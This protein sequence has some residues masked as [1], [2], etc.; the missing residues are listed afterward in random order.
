MHDELLGRAVKCS[1]NQIAEKLPL[2]FILR[3]AGYINVSALLFIS[4]DQSFLRHNLH[5]LQHGRVAGRS[6][7]IDLFVNLSDRARASLPEDAQNLQF[8]I[9]RSRQTFSSH[10]AFFAFLD[11]Q[12]TRRAPYYEGIRIV[13]EKI[14][15]CLTG[16]RL[17]VKWLP[18]KERKRGQGN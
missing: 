17:R 12:I 9:G 3:Q 14:R 5:H 7:F 15:T 2:R 10:K 8:S 18:A 4:L 13:N 11:N 1:F 6:G 16:R